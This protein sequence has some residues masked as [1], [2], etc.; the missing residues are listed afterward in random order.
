MKT[1][2]DSSA[3]VLALHDDAIRSRL[4]RGQSLTR[5]HAL[6]ELFTT[7]TK[8][9]NFRYSPRDA[10]NLLNDLARDL[11]FI[12]LSETDTLKAILS[13]GGQGVRGARIH[14]LLH[15]AAARKGRAT[16]LMTLDEAGFS[17][18]E[19]DLEIQAP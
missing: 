6:A 8:G 15:A 11:D 1:Y 5:P 19:L 12:E 18:L 16:V 14:D 13:A 17:G 10:A 2:W 9:V 4:Q 3:L 7:L